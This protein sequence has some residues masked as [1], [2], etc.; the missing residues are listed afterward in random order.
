MLI[1]L[2]LAGQPRLPT[3]VLV[4]VHI[5]LIPQ[6]KLLGLVA[7]RAYHGAADFRLVT[8]P[9]TLEFR[10]ATVEQLATPNLGVGFR[11]QIALQHKM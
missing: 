1:I 10:E 2:I 8:I 3:A 4:Q 5:F 9:L 6:T 11:R 7:F